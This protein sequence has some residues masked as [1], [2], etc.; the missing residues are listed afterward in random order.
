MPET[1][2]MRQNCA[3]GLSGG[4]DNGCY[5]KSECLL[6]ILNLFFYYIYGGRKWGILSVPTE[7]VLILIG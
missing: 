5:G 4:A 6:A 1:A 7:L 3:E 2:L